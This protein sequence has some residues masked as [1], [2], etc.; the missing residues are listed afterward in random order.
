LNVVQSYGLSR[1]TASEARRFLT[2]KCV[3]LNFSKYLFT[4]T[5]LLSFEQFSKKPL[6]FFI[7]RLEKVS[8]KPVPQFHIPILFYLS[9]AI[10]GV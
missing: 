3:T 10:F 9:G 6:I 1:E 8:S 2:H 7:G 4:S 5:Y